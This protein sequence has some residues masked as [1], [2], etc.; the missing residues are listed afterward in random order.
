MYL[1]LNFFC[2]NLVFGS[3][4]EF[5]KIPSFSLTMGS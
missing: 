5:I 3:L 1:R 2:P 4:N